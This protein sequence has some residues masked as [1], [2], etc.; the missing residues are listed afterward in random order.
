MQLL[1]IRHGIAEEADAF[2]ATGKD[3]SRRPLTKAGKR[4]MKEVVTV[5]ALSPG[6][7][8]SDLVDWLQERASASEDFMKS[9]LLSVVAVV[10]VGAMVGCN[11]PV[12]SA[13]IP[14]SGQNFV[15]HVSEMDA[16][17]RIPPGASLRRMHRE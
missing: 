16:P 10:L 13:P 3:D 9:V 14:P 17:A 15:F 11:D 4:K 6:S 5:E 8:P 1:V 12:R 2:A 7:D